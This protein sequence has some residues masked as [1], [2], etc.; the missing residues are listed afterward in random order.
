[1][2]GMGMVPALS[3]TVQVDYYRK[4]EI[5]V[6]ILHDGYHRTHGN[7]VSRCRFGGHKM[8][9]SHAGKGRGRCHRTR[10]NH[11]VLHVDG[12]VARAEDHLLGQRWL[13]SHDFGF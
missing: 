11:V 1:M 6:V 10:E 7:H 2:A 8:H 3:D 9:E 12:V 5:H 13:G 4:R